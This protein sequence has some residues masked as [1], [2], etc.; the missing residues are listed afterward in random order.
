MHSVSTTPRRASAARP[1]RIPVLAGGPSAEREVSLLSGAA[2]AAALR[3][4]GHNVLISD[5]GPDNLAALEHPA[6]VIFPALHGT[7]GEDGTLQAIMEARGLTYVGSQARASALAMDKD[8]TKHALRGLGV[9]LPAHVIVTAAELAGGVPSIALPVVVKPVDQGSSVATFIVRNKGDLPGALQAVVERYGRAMIEQFIAGDE[10]TV[11]LLDHE[12]LPPLC[13]RP[14]RLFYDYEAK[15]HAEDTEYLFEAG[16][17]VGLLSEARMQS[18]R[19]F[20]HL[21]CRHLGRVDWI[22]D[23][24]GRLWFLEVN[25]IPGFTSHS[26]VPKA[27]AH[28]G[29]C[30]DELVERLVLLALEERHI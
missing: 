27:A 29:I 19:V 25:T 28:V 26:L 12:P 17:S 13:I 24:D 5:I 1:L 6:D 30:F 9:N 20:R 21:G 14:K 3:Q 15:Y 2:V 22:V 23:A 8:R 7:F 4:R 18:L 10:L 11:G 16:F